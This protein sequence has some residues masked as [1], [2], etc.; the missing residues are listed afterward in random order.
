MTEQVLSVERLL[1]LRKLTRAMSDLL[2]DRLTR[3]L[4]TLAPLLRPRVVYGEFLQGPSRDSVRGA[5]RAFRDLQS[6]YGVL[7]AAKPFSLRGELASPFT[8]LDPS[9]DLTPFEYPHVASR[10]GDSRI[11]TVR[12]PLTWVLSYSGF[13]PGR[14]REV[15]STASRSV[16]DVQHC[17]VHTLVMHEVITRQAGVGEILAALGFPLGIAHL[18]AFG[19][20]PITTVSACLSTVRPSDEVIVRAAELSGMD[21]FEEVVNLDDLVHMRDP[22]KDELLNMAGSFGERAAI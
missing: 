21:A 2:H 13:T 5:D 16:E 19:D 18:D 10:D 22:L 12:S 4:T 7:A 3:Y 1:V 8:I 14:V 20:L 6:A 17:L 11:V 15:L 9:I